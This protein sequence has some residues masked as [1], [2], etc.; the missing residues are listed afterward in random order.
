MK[1]NILGIAE[2]VL[3]ALLTVGSFTFF[4]ACGEHEGKFMACHWAQNAVTLIGIVITLLALLRIILKN[5]G[6]K[7]GLAIGVFA[8]AA[9]VIFIPDNVISLC[10]MDTMSCHTTFKP[11]VIVIASVLAAAAG[12]DSVLGIIKAGKSN[13]S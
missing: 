3:A 8:S 10:M 4:K 2:L 9:A 6:I 12:V 11:A 5:S 13:E 7:A 1:K